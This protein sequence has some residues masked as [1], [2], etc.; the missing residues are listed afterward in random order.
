MSLKKILLEHCHSYVKDKEQ[1]LIS[2]YQLLQD[3]LN[4]ETKSTAG[5]KHE[6]GRAMV[7]LEQEKLEKQEREL[8]FVRQTLQKITIDKTASNASLGSLV[9]TDDQSYFLAVFAGAFEDANGK[10]FC[11]SVA[12][13]IGQCLLGKTSGDTLNFNG[14]AIK[15]LKIE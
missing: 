1:K 11:V 12:S 4:N 14:K 2:R 3:S 10:V 5:D 7:Q 13:P 9:V 6:T 15:I 8:K